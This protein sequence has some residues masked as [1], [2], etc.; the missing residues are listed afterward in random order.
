[1]TWAV[2]RKGTSNGTPSKTSNPASAALEKSVAVLP[3]DNFSADK[4]T[5]YLSDG[6]TEEI[7]AALARVPG[8]RVAA[9]NSAF[10][11]KT[12]KQD[13][14]KIGATLGVATILEGSLRKAGNRIRV[15]AQLINA[16]D[17]LHLWA[18]T[19]DRSV[20]DILTVQEDIA[21]KIAD[22]FEL[23]PSGE[24]SSTASRQLA[25]N[26]EAYAF[27]LKGLHAWNK[28]TKEDLAQAAQLFKQAIDKDPT[29]AA[30]YAG[31][32]STYVLLPEYSSRP[33]SEYSPLA[34][35]AAEKA[36]A[37]DSSSADAYTVLGLVASYSR[38]YQKA[39]EQFQRAIR[40]NP[41][42]ATAHHW[43]GVLLRGWNR[44]DEAGV[45][46][47]RAEALDPLSPIIKMNLLAWMG[48]KRDYQSTLEQC[49]R[50]MEQF[51]DFE[52]LRSVR[53]LLLE[54]LGRYPEALK[55]ILASRATVTNTPY[56]L[57]MVGFIYAR[58][59]DVDNARKILVELESYK[60]QG[61][62]VCTDIAQVH[63]GLKEFDPAMDAFEEALTK[64]E[65]L[66][67]LLVDPT[68]DEIRPLPRFQ[69][70]LQK[71]GLK[72]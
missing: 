1:V 22:R 71:L 70:L 46:L 11:F 58:S 31:L 72:K 45:E 62:A 59:G 10:V 60:K 64:G 32:A 13:L 51:P 5:D 40:L 9:R 28:R 7:T 39:E 27:Y 21:S 36:L 14:R 56:F 50:Y 19:Y 38:Q 37:L 20:D 63:V 41:N 49:D 48:L 26:Q 67:D 57:G 12:Q 29:Y 33:Q 52:L 54:R 4:D 69:A 53:A 65:P 25:P 16:A 42:Q 35:A 44:M 18:D 43:Y 23:K 3:F 55:D 6:L 8:L 24:P 15:T 66:I 47:H 68:L 2:M 17:G 61:Y 30:A 34:S